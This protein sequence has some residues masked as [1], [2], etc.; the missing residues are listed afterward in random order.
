MHTSKKVVESKQKVQAKHD[1][2]LI[3]LLMVI[4]ALPVASEAPPTESATASATSTASSSPSSSPTSSAT[5]SASATPTGQVRCTKGYFSH[6]GFA[7]C[8]PCS[9]GTF[10]DGLMS[11]T[12]ALC[13]AGRYGSAAGLSSADCSGP[14]LGC[15]AG[16]A[17]PPPRTSL[18]CTSSGTRAIPR[19]LGVLLWPAAHPSNP[20][21]VDLVIAPMDVCQRLGGSCSTLAL[22]TAVGADGLARYIVGTAD[23]L[24]LEPAETLAC[25][26]P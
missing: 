17:F 14:C 16:T 13:P 24:H 7:P 20:Q 11:Q 26:E 1:G 18:S 10:S 23:A 15:P 5:S 3:L 9:P 22:N 19:S 2:I 25:N 8:V 4:V 21:H 6:T 12:C